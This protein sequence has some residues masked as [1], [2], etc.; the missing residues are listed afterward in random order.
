MALGMVS[1]E[2]IDELALCGIYLPGAASRR[3]GPLAAGLA[4][5]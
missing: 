3:S 4:H 5:A 2:D 1:Q